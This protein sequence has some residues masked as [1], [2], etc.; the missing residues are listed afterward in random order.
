MASSLKTAKTYRELS[1]Q[2]ED[3]LLWFESGDVDLD[4]AVTKYEEAQ[5]LLG[6]MEKYLKT[7]ENKI[8]KISAVK[9]SK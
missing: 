5:K 1:E 8:H 7:A 2:L 3:I 9:T 6:E 4:E